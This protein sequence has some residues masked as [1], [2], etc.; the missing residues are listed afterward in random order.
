MGHYRV[1]GTARLE[2]IWRSQRDG[3]AMRPLA[4]S[5]EGRPTTASEPAPAPAADGAV[6]RCAVR[7]DADCIAACLI[8]KGTTYCKQAVAKQGDSH[9]GAHC[10]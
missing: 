4:E 8:G 1:W 2:R 10:V 7:R 9:S 3:P 5:I 6:V